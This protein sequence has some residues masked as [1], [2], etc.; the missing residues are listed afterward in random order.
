MIHTQSGSISRFLCALLLLAGLAGSAVRAE[1]PLQRAKDLAYGQ[2]LYAY[3]QGHAFEA[4]SL[5]SAATL[6]G[7]IQ[8]HG[9]HPKLVEGGLMLSYGMV[10][11]A[12]ALFE[13]VLKEQL[14]IDD[15]NI[16]WFYLGKVFYLQQ[17]HEQAL[18]SFKKIQQGELKAA[19]PEKFYEL[20]YLKGQMASVID[21]PGATQWL[22]DLPAGHIFRFYLRYNQA[23]DLM[24]A[25]KQDKAL[26]SLSSLAEDLRLLI[27]RIEQDPPDLDEPAEPE[28]N[29]A[30][31][32]ETMELRALLDQVLLT[33]AQF[34]LQTEQTEAALSGLK[35]IDKQGPFAA[36]ALFL[37]ALA[38]SQL[39]HY[40]LALSALTELKELK[41]LNPWR[42]QSPYALAYLYEQMLEPVIA[43]EA[44]RAAVGHYEALQQKLLTE[45]ETLNESSVLSALD[46]SNSIGQTALTTDAYG[47]VLSDAGSFNFAT[48][49]ASEAF[50]VVLSELHELYVL[51]NSLVSWERQ[52]ASFDVMLETRQ[53]ARREKLKALQIELEAKDVTSWQQKTEH[54][55][56]QIEQ[57]EQDENPYYFMTDA[58]LAY[59]KRIQKTRE[60]LQNLPDSH[61]DKS[62]YQLRLQRIQAYFDWW[63]ADEYSVNRWR[64]VKQLKQ[65]QAQ[66]ARFQQAIEGLASQQESDAAHLQFS[67][68]LEDGKERLKYL[69][70]QI[71][72]SLNRAR[73]HLLSLV[74]Q[75][76][77]LQL[78]E[79]GAYL[80]ASREALARV[81]DQ[82]LN[83]TQTQTQKQNQN[84]ELNKVENKAGEGDTP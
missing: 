1:E 56:Q 29:N 44:Y 41:H 28:N 6:R 70:S 9:E 17:N 43:L 14:T 25:Q 65:L 5:L 83:Q 13:A 26:A 78:D 57:A 2:I 11:E 64:T 79:I 23:L 22:S 18:S 53:L 71:E 74:D 12:K 66:M 30:V 54:F 84:A 33:Q 60:R 62:S 40:E 42:Q 45:R 16:A 3:H 39:Q 24:Q 73:S 55:R 75:A 59:F 69:Q 38:A 34:Q 27:K 46:L 21:S 10:H 35:G 49:L 7:G 67:Q 52:L 58:Q 36:Q 77:Q 50:Q 15:R 19:D 81:S 4:L 48:L 20:L 31:I 51:K 32:G 72:L 8:G 76:M 82:L 61:P 37:Y 68:R 63:I 80:L 47:R